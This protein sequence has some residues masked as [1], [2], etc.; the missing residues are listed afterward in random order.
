MAT[1]NNVVIANVAKGGGNEDIWPHIWTVTRAMKKAGWKYLASGDGTTK[2][3]SADP[4]NDGW[5]AGTSTG[6]TGSAA[7]FAASTVRGRL[8]VTGLSGITADS[9]GRFLSFTGTSGTTNDTYAQ[10]E[11]VVSATEVYV[12]ARSFTFSLPEANNG[13]INWDEIDPTLD[14]LPGGLASAQAWILMRGPSTIKIP[15]T[16]APTPGSSGFD[17]IRGEN[18]AQANT[19]AEG[20]ILGYVFDSDAATGYLVVVTRVIGNGADPFGWDDGAGSNTITGATSGATVNQNG[21]ALEYRQQV[22]FHKEANQDSGHIYHQCIE[23]VGESADDFT[24]LA[25]AAGCTATVQPGGGGTGNSFPAIAFTN[26]GAG[27]STTG[28]KWNGF[29]F[30]VNAANGQII[31]V[32]AIWEEDH[33]PDGSWAAYTST[34]ISG[35]PYGVRGFYRLDDHEPGDVDPFVTLGMSGATLYNSSAR[36]TANQTS[37]GSANGDWMNTENSDSSLGTSHVLLRGW[38]RRG[39]GSDDAFSCFEFFITF[40]NQSNGPIYQTNTGTPATVATALVNTKARQ[41]LQVGSVGTTGKMSKGT[42]RHLSIVQGGNPNATYDGGKFVQ[43]SGTNGGFVFGP[44]DEA[45]V[46]FSS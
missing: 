22:V 36:T 45:T 31:A 8:Q 9:K 21:V 4:A 5:G 42:I 17:F 16:T 10:I 25:A 39:F 12:D 43:A 27:G 37:S 23:P 29:N 41:P 33:S 13:S 19:G 32:D 14:S 24:T 26:I 2:D 46:P 40:A 15:I 6:N 38:R 44:W 1:V 30:A 34:T 3:T 35:G 20:E 7:S 28:S 11:E 18:V